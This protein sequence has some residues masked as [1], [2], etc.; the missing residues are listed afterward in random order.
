MREDKNFAFSAFAID[1][2]FHNAFNHTNIDVV[3]QKLRDLP[4]PGMGTEAFID[5]SMKAI[6]LLK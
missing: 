5:E 2:P 6:W 1:D 4:I 3:V